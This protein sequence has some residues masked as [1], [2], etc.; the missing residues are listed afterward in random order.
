MKNKNSFR[1]EFLQKRNQ[2]TAVKVQNMSQKIC[3]HLIRMDFF[4]QAETVCFYYPLGNE[5]SLLTVAG[6]ALR[7][8]KQV[9]FPRTEGDQI[10]FYPVDHLSDFREGRF[11]VME[12]TGSKPLDVAALHA[13]AP[14][15]ILVPGVV[16]DRSRN[17]M[18]YGKGFYD[19]YLADLT[20]MTRGKVA[21]DNGSQVI[22]IG[23][24]Y[25]CQITEMIPTEATDIPM[26]YILTENGIW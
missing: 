11:H 16:F 18:G 20:A 2:L 13:Q 19:R 12:P 15:L 3:D 8:G 26:D 9:A 4:Q 10:R 25:E 7:M 17:R 6:E 24:A 23:I 21:N 1:Q 14:L 22:T 5:A